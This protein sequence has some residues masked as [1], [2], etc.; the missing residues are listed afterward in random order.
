[1]SIS[2]SDKLQLFAQKIQRF[3]SQHFLHDLARDV[4]LC[5]Q[6]KVLISPEG[7]NQRFNK[8]AAVQFLR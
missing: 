7:L 6:A 2:A 4:G 1:M 8:A 3:L 5:N